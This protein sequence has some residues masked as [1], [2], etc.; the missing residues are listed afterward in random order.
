MMARLPKVKEERGA[1]SAANDLWFP[2][3]GKSILL[4]EQRISS[5]EEKYELMKVRAVIP[6]FACELGG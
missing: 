3:G 5:L 6:S 1:S 2:S 4:T